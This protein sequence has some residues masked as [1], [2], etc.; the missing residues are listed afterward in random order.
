MSVWRIEGQEVT[1][2]LSAT[3]EEVKQREVFCSWQ[4]MAEQDQH[5]AAP[6]EGQIGHRETLLYYEDGETSE[7][8]F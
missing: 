5:K 2:Q 6:G 4:M 8:T 1:S 3:Y 7:Q